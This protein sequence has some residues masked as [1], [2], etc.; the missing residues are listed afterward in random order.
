MYVCWNLGKHVEFILE[1]YQP[2]QNSFKSQV[3]FHYFLIFIKEKP[4]HQA[5]GCMLKGTG[6]AV[7][8]GDLHPRPKL[9]KK[10]QP[11]KTPVSC[12]PVLP[13]RLCLRS[14]RCTPRQLTPEEGPAAK[15]LTGEQVSEVSLGVSKL[16]LTRGSRLP[17]TGLWVSWHALPWRGLQALWERCWSSGL[18]VGWWMAL[19]TRAD[20]GCVS[21][22]LEHLRFP[23]PCP[24]FFNSVS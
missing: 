9:V 18:L 19:P 17:S 16:W 11:K 2:I 6:R 4:H 21:L 5:M 20:L 10:M 13:S 12:Q 15:H 7:L 3:Y 24:C 1:I 22:S 14:V 8:A 23:S